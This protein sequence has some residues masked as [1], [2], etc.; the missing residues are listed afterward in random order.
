M[1][2]GID[3]NNEPVAGSEKVIAADTVCL[4]IGLVPNV[5]LLSLL[6]CDLT[7][8]SELGGYAP[9]HRSGRGL[10]PPAFPN[11]GVFR[12]QG[13]LGESPPMFGKRLAG[14]IVFRYACV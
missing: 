3:G 14:R 5:E 1:L 2:V 12:D 9:V 6:D 10:D 13:E 11:G 7:F 8:K 4:A